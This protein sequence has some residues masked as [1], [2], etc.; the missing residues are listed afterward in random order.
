MANKTLLTTFAKQT[1]LE[2][3][4]FSPVAVVPPNLVTPITA[5]YCFLSKVDPWDD[6]D[7]PPIPQQDQKY[8]K[9]TFKNMFVA[10]K[11]TANDISPVIPRI[12][13]TYGITY[14]YYQD[15]VDIF[16]VDENGFANYKFYVKNRYDQIF[17]CLWNNNNTP[18]T[19][20]PYFEPGTYGTDNIFRGSDDYKW[21]YMYT[22]DDGLRV[23]FLDSNWIPVPIGTT[24]PNPLQ[25]D[26]GTGDIPVINITN[27]GSGYDPS[28]AV[29]SIV[30]TGDGTG[31]TA[32]AEVDGDEIADVIV[33]NPGTNYTYA[34]VAI[35][36]AIGSNATAICPVSPISGHAFDPISELGCTKV[37]V[38]VEFNASENG[39]IP[40]DIDYHQLGIIVNP[41]TRQLSPIPANG[42]IYKTTTDLVVASGQGAYTNDE[43]VYQGTS[44]QDAY[45]TGRVLSFDAGTNTI[46]LINTEGTLAYNDSVHG[47]V[48][49]TVRTLLTYSTPNFVTQSGYM[50][51]IENRTGIVRSEDGIEQFKIVLG[52]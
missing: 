45:F 32:T 44:L 21:K 9:Q 5:M 16:D 48:S 23:K 46:K 20:E 28:N 35:V 8:I 13:W 41:T 43:I 27:R 19:I 14:D 39:N 18:S 52:Y 24:N 26:A 33:T 10:K 49:G 4:Y 12:D 17:K 31:A 51:F 34:N 50:I 22:I 42:A 11:I 15:D 36:S 6:E 38:A 7:N 29:I 25:S 1:S 2:Q 40:I 47:T 37:M 3:F 30:I